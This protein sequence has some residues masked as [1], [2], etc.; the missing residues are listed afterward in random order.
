M[1][2]RSSDIPEICFHSDFAGG[3]SFAQATFS[4]WA[5]RVFLLF[6]ATTTAAPSDLGGGGTVFADGIST[7]IHFHWKN[8]PTKT[9]GYLPKMLFQ[10][11]PKGEHYFKSYFSIRTVLPRG[12]AQKLDSCSCHPVSK[13]H[14]LAFWTVVDALHASSST[15]NG[16][17][18]HQCSTRPSGEKYQKKMRASLMYC[19][20]IKHKEIGV[21]AMFDMP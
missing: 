8:T 6:A 21:H 16:V 5:W 18:L 20:K 14:F 2:C 15:R 3:F 1:S 10:E 17:Q 4:Q 7:D 9:R 13:C 12:L 11:Y 19:S